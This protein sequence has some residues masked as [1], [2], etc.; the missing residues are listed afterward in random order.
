[1]PFRFMP[2][3]MQVP[4]SVY[5]SADHQFIVTF[6]VQRS[7]DFR[8]YNHDGPEI[9]AYRIQSRIVHHLAQEHA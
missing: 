5:V 9:G 1:M 3:L 2:S 4:V 6:K 7:H 8:I